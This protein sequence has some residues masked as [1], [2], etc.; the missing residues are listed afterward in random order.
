MQLADHWSFNFRKDPKILGFFLARYLFASK[1][2]RDKSSILELGCSEGMAVSSLMQKGKS[3]VGIDFDDLSIKAAKERFPFENYTF[4][5]EDFLGKFYGKF[6]AVISIDVIEHIFLENESLFFQTVYKNLKEDG[7]VVIG[8]PNKTAEAYASEAS[9]AGHVNLYT[10]ERLQKKLL[11]YFHQAL[12]FGI[13]DE[14]V[15]TGF[16]NMCHYL[17]CVAFHKREKK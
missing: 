3:Y 9:N 15:H 1:M 17:F 4:F 5:S 2:I 13:N 6:D 16:G 7:I 11:E 8:T 14:V 10:Q 12:C